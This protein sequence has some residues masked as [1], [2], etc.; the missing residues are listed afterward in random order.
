MVYVVCYGVY[1]ATTG[2]KEKVS[3]CPPCGDSATL[4]YGGG[5]A[6]VNNHSSSAYRHFSDLI[7]N[8]N[9]SYPMAV[10]QLK[11]ATDLLHGGGHR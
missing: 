7:N 6:V 9:D 8:D 5:H 11:A 10:M 2:G 3:K 4:P 1:V